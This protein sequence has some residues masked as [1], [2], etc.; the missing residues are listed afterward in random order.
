MFSFKNKKQQE[1]YK[2]IIDA[3]HRVLGVV[4]FA[5]DGTILEAN[6]NFLQIMGYKLDEIKGKHHRI[7]TDTAT[8]QSHE[9]RQFWEKLNKGEFVAAEFKRIRSDKNAIYIQA[10]YNPI[11]DSTGKIYKIV[12]FATDVTQ[13]RIKNAK[14][15]AQLK[16][17]NLSQATIEFTPDG[18][19]LDANDNF[20]QIMGYKLD[21]FKGKHHSMFVS[22]EHKNSPAYKNFWEVLR[23][24]TFHSGEFDRYKKNGELIV[25]SAT[26][27]PVF[28]D[29]GKLQSVIKIASDITKIKNENIQATNETVTV[30]EAI[31]NGNLT[32]SMQGQYNNHFNQVQLS[33]N[34]TVQS[35]RELIHQ[36]QSLA[37][38]TSS[39]SKDIASSVEDLATR[40]EA[41]AGSLEEAAATMEQLASTVRE[42]F[43]HTLHAKES[44]ENSQSTAKK[45]SD[46]VAKAIEAMGKIETS[47]SKIFEIIGLIDE[48]AFQTNL[49][50]LNA[51]VEAAR[52]GEAGRGFAVVADEVRNLAQ[53]SADA[54][55]QIKVLIQESGTHVKEG[56]TFV[57]NMEHSLMEIVA[58]SEEV[59]K[60][61]S[62]IAAATKEQ[63]IGIDQI[64]AVISQID[65]STQR[66]AALVQSSTSS[67]QSLNKSAQQLE[68]LA[69]RFR[70]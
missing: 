15:E 67:S 69:E 13:R 27:N 35:L 6:D 56:S 63:S 19:I 45:G 51:S 25:I 4:E 24:G 33:L 3:L 20:L 32:I 29:D 57:S 66:N 8:Q 7:F 1:S 14:Y 10:S 59:A 40:T 48:I 16:A 55:K 54:S 70:T 39:T 49:L 9:Y 22:A 2:H 11:F 46:V 21:E 61:I 30:L 12:K 18:M 41:Q 44:A 42:N 38:S 36:V 62:E 23:S 68:E 58:S 64:N 52:D 53:R 5:P 50:A 17:L 31:K 37:A 47:S 28:D 65:S 34:N 60:T 43:E 26:Y